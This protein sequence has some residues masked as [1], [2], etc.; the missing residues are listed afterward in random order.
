M[1][2]KLAQNSE[3]TKHAEDILPP[4][5]VDVFAGC[6]GLSLGLKKAG[7]HG[8]FA[9]EKDELAFSTLSENFLQNDSRYGYMWP[10]WL[11]KE[12]HDIDEIIE[13]HAEHLK[14]LNGQVDL[15]AGGPPCQGFSSAG[16]R[17]P[18]D[19]RNKLVSSYLK[20]VDLLRPKIV[21]LENVR[22]ITSDFSKQTDKAGTINFA[23]EIVDRLSEH[24]FVHMK[25]VRA[26]DF[27][28]PQKRPR[29]IFIGFLKSVFKGTDVTKPFE[30]LSK[31]SEVFLRERGLT[32]DMPSQDAISDLETETNPRI[33]CPDCKGYEAIGYVAPKTQY[34]RLMR[35]GL[36]QEIHDTRLAK[37][38]PHIVERFADIISICQAQNH[39][40]VTIP[41]EVKEK[42]K[43]KKS[44][45][46]VLDPQRP[47]PTVTSMPDDL[48]HYSE[49]RTLTVRENARLQSFPDWFCFKGKYTSGGDRRK[50][51]VP[52]FT[53][54]A[55]AVPPL[56]AEQ[57]GIYLR[58]KL[59]ELVY[60][61]QH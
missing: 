21:L 5:F 50:H 12:A 43:L 53:Q 37:H 30:K 51:E 46:R 48:L 10:S 44:A 17:N 61:S 33:P 38:R 45:I 20:F 27:G 9:I 13:Q 7:W 34:Q 4:C 54:V 26:S 29:V 19:P 22:G 35:M 24:Y 31:V 59:E 3:K 40:S 25:L 23:Q 55:N 28:V 60:N 41:K 15:L 49:P 2:D 57:I 52:R 58:T 1:F 32:A 39:L 14:A 36:S 42:Y 11:T 8:L 47:A 16:R 6:G 18:N 56:L